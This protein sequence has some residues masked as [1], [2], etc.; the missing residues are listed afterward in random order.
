[1]YNIIILLTFDNTNNN[2]ELE[3]LKH[4]KEKFYDTY[5]NVINM[6]YEMKEIIINVI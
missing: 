2:N 5:S 6:E 1:M 4:K 3:L